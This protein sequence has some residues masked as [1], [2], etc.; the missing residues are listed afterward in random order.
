MTISRVSSTYILDKAML[1]VHQSLSNMAKLQEQIASGRNLSMPSDD[2]LQFTRLLNLNEDA[3]LDLLY[4]Q[5]ID[6]GLSELG[7]AETATNGIVDITHRV[8][9]LTVQAANGI[10][11]DSQLQAIADEIDALTS[12]TVQLG[13]TSFAGRFIFSGFKTESAAF[14]D[15]GA[16]GI[17]YD[18]SPTNNYA[19]QVQVGK[20]T[21]V[22]INING[23][24]LLGE[25]TLDTTT[26]EPTAGSG[27]LHT[28]KKIKYDLLNGDFDAIRADIGTISTDQGNVLALQSQ[29]GSRTS[30]LEMIKNRLN[31]RAVIQAQEVGKIQEVDMP[32]AISNLNFQQT[33]YQ[34]SLGVLSKIMETSLVNFLR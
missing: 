28:L 31:D 2:P 9:E 24:D 32:K 11:N 10:L 8:R 20:N 29:I 17:T 3:G 27:L 16:T 21:F 26:G 1:S 13:N 5:N 23:S 14:T 4:S 6:V 34:G 12:Q 7:A 19:R 33:L 30:Q 22:T 15:G 25:V 18:G